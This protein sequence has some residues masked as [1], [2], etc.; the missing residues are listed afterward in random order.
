MQLG[1]ERDVLDVEGGQFVAQDRGLRAVAPRD[2]GRY[3]V[4]AAL[5]G[6]LTGAEDGGDDLIR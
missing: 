2:T 5:G 4:M 6:A 3:Q 1:N